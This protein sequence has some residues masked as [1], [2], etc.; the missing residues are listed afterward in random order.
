MKQI[1]A[2]CKQLGFPIHT[3]CQALFYYNMISTNT[4][5]HTNSIMIGCISLASKVSETVKRLRDIL[6]FFDSGNRDQIMDV[7]RML[8]QK[9]AFYPSYIDPFVLL[10]S[11]A[12]SMGIDFD[13]ASTAW[14]YLWLLLDFYDSFIFAKYPSHVISIAALY[15]AHY[16]HQ[17]SFDH[18]LAEY[19]C[20]LALLKGCRF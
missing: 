5:H 1:V 18:N 3:T 16:H 14:S 10:P 8:L 11:I 20:S 9:T 6:S 2:V 17:C 19:H 13:L 4:N 7:E 12:K 15:I